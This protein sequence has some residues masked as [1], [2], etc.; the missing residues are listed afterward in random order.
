MRPLRI[1]TAGNVLVPSY[2][3]LGQKGY[4]IWREASA[5]EAEWWVAE[6]PLG[7]FSAEDPLSLL[8]LVAMAETRGDEWEA[9]DEEIDAYLTKFHPGG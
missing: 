9:S 3:A 4:R 8:G 7:R 2:L 6:G 1:A 5:S